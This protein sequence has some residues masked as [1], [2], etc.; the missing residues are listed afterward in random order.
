MNTWTH[1]ETGW[2]KWPLRSKLSYF[3]SLFIRVFIRSIHDVHD[4][5]R[6][7]VLLKLNLNF[8][9]F[10]LCVLYYFTS[11]VISRNKQTKRVLLFSPYDV[12]DVYI[13]FCFATDYLVTNFIWLTYI[14]KK[15]LICLFWLDCRINVCGLWNII[16]VF[17]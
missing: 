3:I 14:W 2:R 12:D 5:I 10:I 7:L 6:K 9:L 16:Y 1:R 11:F 8:F 17:R 13:K 4:D 15:Q